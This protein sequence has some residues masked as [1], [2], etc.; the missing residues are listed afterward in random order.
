[1]VITL[2]S[3]TNGLESPVRHKSA[4][5]G[6][7]LITAGILRYWKPEVFGTMDPKWRETEF[8]AWLDKT[9]ASLCTRKSYL[10]TLKYYRGYLQSHANRLPPGGMS[11]GAHLMHVQ[12]F[13]DYLLAGHRKANTINAM[14]TALKAY[15]KFLGYGGHN[16]KFVPEQRSKGPEALTANQLARFLW[17]VNRLDVRD[18]A[19]ILTALHAGLTPVELHRLNQKDVTFFGKGVYVRV[20]QGGRNKRRQVRAGM[21]LWNALKPHYMEMLQSG[22]SSDE[23]DAPLWQGKTGVRLGVR[24]L[25]SILT[26]ISY[27][28]GFKVSF[29]H[30]RTT[31][32]AGQAKRSGATIRKLSAISGL[33]R[34]R[35][36]VKYQKLTAI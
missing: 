3:E 2:P 35:T 19:I 20:N 5:T 30:L 15:Y 6:G 24:A 10:S 17:I 29:A 16:I 31:W 21:T 7:G 34:E 9:G 32:L 11:C 28:L 23:P 36:I 33:K 8:D 14:L 27:V 25:Q 12:G 4:T 18:R 26:E 13:K 1:M 22:Q